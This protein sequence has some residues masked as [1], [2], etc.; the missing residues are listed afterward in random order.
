MRPYDL[1]IENA[2]DGRMLED[3]RNFLIVGRQPEEGTVQRHLLELR[4]L[5]DGSGFDPSRLR[6]DSCS[7]GY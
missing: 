4:M 6:E 1:R 3:F 7:S 2:K 5:F